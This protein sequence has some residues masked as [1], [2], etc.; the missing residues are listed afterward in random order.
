MHRQLLIIALAGLCCICTLQPAQSQDFTRNY[1]SGTYTTGNGLADMTICSLF[2]DLRGYLWIGTQA[3]LSRFDGLGFRNYYTTDGLRDNESNDIIQLNKDSLSVLTRNGFS[4]IAGDN[5]SSFSLPEG[6]TSQFWSYQAVLNN[7]LYLFNVTPLPTLSASPIVHY[8]FDFKSRQFTPL[9]LPENTDIIKALPGSNGTIN[10][11]TRK[12]YWWQIKSG[13]L[14]SVGRVAYSLLDICK[15]GSEQLY[16]Y[17]LQQQAFYTLTLKDRF[18]DT[19]R[20]VPFVHDGFPL[21]HNLVGTSTGDLYFNNNNDTIFRVS[22]GAIEP[23]VVSDEEYQDI[24]VDK[25]NAL[26][27]GSTKGL[28]A[29]YN[30]YFRELRFKKEG[31]GMVLAILPGAGAQTWFNGH[32][33]GIWRLENNTVKTLQPGQVRGMDQKTERFFLSQLQGAIRLPNGRLYFPFHYGLIEVDKDG[34]NLHYIERASIASMIEDET[35]NNLY[36][37][38]Y[39]GLLKWVQG[40]GYKELF[41]PDSYN[42]GVVYYLYKDKQ[43]NR[44]AFTYKGAGIIKNDTI[45]PVKDLDSLSVVSMD[46]DTR[47]R[48]WIATKRGLFSY[49][50]GQQPSRVAPAIFKGEVSAV[51]A[52]DSSTLVVVDNQRLAFLD[53]P[54][55]DSPTAW[56]VYDN[57][58]GYSGEDYL[59]SKIYKDSSG[60]IWLPCSDKVISCNPASIIRQRSLPDVFINT[61]ASSNDNVSWQTPGDATQLLH[62][63]EG[64]RN[65]KI[66]FLSVYLADPRGIRYQYRLKGLNEDWS[67]ATSDNNVIYSHLGA[68]H[69][70]FEVRCSADGVRWSEA[71][72]QISFYMPP[73]WWQ[74]WW[75]ITLLVISA[76]VLLWL[77]SRYYISLR[78]KQQMRRLEKQLAIEQER[79]RISGEI[80][81]DLGAGLSGIRLQAELASRKASTPEMKTELARIYNVASELSARMREVIWSLNTENDTLEKLLYYMQQEGYKLFEHTDIKFRSTYPQQLPHIPVSGQKRRDIYLI[82]KEALHNAMKHSEAT[83]ISLTATVQQ[84]TLLI[85][86]QD[87][88]KGMTQRTEEEGNGMRNMQQRAAKTG[89]H[90][91]IDNGQGVAVHISIDITSLAK[92]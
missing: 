16:Y 63:P 40:Q 77:L 41:F 6:I 79:H 82:V 9:A 31:N 7:K 85:T 50:R 70:T 57:Y 69:Y 14:D 83:E 36:L 74:T 59:G 68:G 62:L 55:A 32:N 53:L 3:G 20:Y 19:T 43:E 88:G 78:W 73:F 45:H 48:Y 2:Q 1:T 12:G 29:W 15:A 33:N 26:W 11:F 34:Y 67:A 28:R 21:K 84:D 25:F 24:M 92:H 51:L 17:D 22:K 87:N 76:G 44:W 65:I 42:K 30:L 13:K 54:N 35:G 80:H 47:G 81:D 56:I 4:I 8:T 60:T 38:T 49:S 71:T 23:V 75:F 39:R 89:G 10:I 91:Q 64:D 66:E 18:F 27:L 52:Y 37:A 90:L 72:A 46:Q 5:V 61:F 86:V 58:T